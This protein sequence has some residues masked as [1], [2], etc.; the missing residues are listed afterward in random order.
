MDPKMAAPTRENSDV[1]YLQ[2]T[3]TILVL[4]DFMAKLQNSV[5]QY[6]ISVCP[7]AREDN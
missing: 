7:T 3:S 2:L 6:G 4:L 5:Q 1:K